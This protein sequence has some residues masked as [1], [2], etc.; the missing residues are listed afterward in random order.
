MDQELVRAV[1]F[2]TKQAENRD[3]LSYAGYVSYCELVGVDPP[4]LERW[5]PCVACAPSTT[6]NRSPASR[7]TPDGLSAIYPKYPP[8]TVAPIF[9]NL[10]VARNSFVV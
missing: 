9:K 10:S 5:Q 8:D 3:S 4:P 6:G 1:E 2:A 7:L